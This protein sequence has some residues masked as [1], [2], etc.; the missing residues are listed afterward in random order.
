[1]PR[2]ATSRRS[3]ESGA[4]AN[5][6]LLLAVVLITPADATCPDGASSCEC[7]AGAFFVAPSLRCSGSCPCT[8]WVGLNQSSIFSNS[9]GSPFYDN[10]S[11]CEWTLS[12]VNPQVR[13]EYFETEGG[14][15]YAYVDECDGAECLPLAALTG[16]MEPGQLYTWESSTSHL[17][18]RFTSDARITKCGFTA[19]VS[20][21][22]SGCLP[23]EAGTYK[24]ASDASGCT[25]CPTNAV[26]AEGSSALSSCECPAGYTGD[27]GAGEDCVW[28]VYPNF[29]N[30]WNL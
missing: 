18:V 23:C 3:L 2:S 4:M 1:M 24:A 7:A 27:A 14:H 19:T 13:F 16:H 21:G 8:P 25:A 30:S 12:G 28:K 10:N 11:Y 29:Y 17:R 15:D 9:E 22:A 26:S 6:V 20:G 5:V